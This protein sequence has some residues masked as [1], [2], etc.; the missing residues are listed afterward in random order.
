VPPGAIIDSARVRFRTDEVSAGPAALRIQAEATDDSAPFLAVSRNLTDRTRTVASVDWSPAPW[1]T[2]GVTGTDQTTP[3]ISSVLQ[4]VV[5]RPGWTAGNHATILVSGSGR[6]TADAFEDGYASIL[7]I[8]WHLPLAGTN[9]APV[10]LAGPD[11]QVQLPDAASLAGSVSDDGLPVP[12]GDVTA[13]WSTLSGPGAVA[14]GD[15]ASAS[16]TAT[17]SDPGE[18]VLQLTADDGELQTTDQVTV[19]VLPIDTPQSVV[20]PLAS[21]ADDAEQVLTGYMNVGDPDLELGQDGTKP[22]LV[23]LRYALPVPAGAV[24]DSAVVQLSVDEVGSDPADLVIQAEAADSAAAFQAVS[25]NLTDRARTAASVSWAPAPWT[26]V[27]ARGPDQMTPD[28]AVVLQ[29]VVDRAGWSAGNSVALLISGTGRRTANAF[30]DGAAAELS[31]T[32]HMPA[33]QG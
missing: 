7:D 31:L 29:E 1:P 12:P 20:I 11:Q 19:T 4:R 24:I 10:A 23:G 2:V 26:T 22:Q 17:F 30:G 9:R 5:D 28:V 16:T 18:Y 13:A 15:P 25:R 8:T 21:G 32:W 14:F 3:D 6:R 27:N 33:T